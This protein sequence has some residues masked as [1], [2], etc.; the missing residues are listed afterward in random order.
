MGCFG[1]TVQVSAGVYAQKGWAYAKATTYLSAL[2]FIL[3]G[4]SI[5]VCGSMVFYMIQ[6]NEEPLRAVAVFC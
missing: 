5:A 1:Q 6:S 2:C 3:V 4:Y